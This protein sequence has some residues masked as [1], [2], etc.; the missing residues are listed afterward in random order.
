M[1][2]IAVFAFIEIR[3]GSKLLRT[4]I[5][6]VQPTSTREPMPKTPTAAPAE[7]APSRPAR[8]EGVWPVIGRIQSV[9]SPLAWLFILP[10]TQPVRPQGPKG[11]PRSVCARMRN[12]VPAQPPAWRVSYPKS[13]AT[14]KS[15]LVSTGMKRQGFVGRRNQEDLEIGYVSSDC[16]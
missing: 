10:S 13:Y 9:G 14:R 8:R 11:S 6:K 5:S 7:T 15:N 16:R 2:A 4:G 3:P 1:K 12:L